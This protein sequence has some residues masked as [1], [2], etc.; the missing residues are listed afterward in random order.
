M[1]RANGIDSGFSSPGIVYR[2]A[3]I[4]SMLQKS[5]EKNIFI[6]APG[7]YGKT[8]ATAQWLASVRGATARITV[9]G[10]DNDQGVFYGRLARAVFKL[11]GKEEAFP[12]A[13]YTPDVFFEALTL[14]P[15]KRARC[16]LLIDD[17]HMLKNEDI[18]RKSVV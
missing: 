14:L 13:K 9:C 16:Y 11:A 12:N 6:S 4:K 15:A 2:T 8:V 18:D 3:L 1:D 5:R 10:T 17:L 7:G